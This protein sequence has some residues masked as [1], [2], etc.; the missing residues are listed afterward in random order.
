MNRLS[1]CKNMN[2]IRK[3][4][5]IDI[6]DSDKIE[7]LFYERESIKGILSFM[8]I[9]NIEVTNEIKEEYAKK[10]ARA[11]LEFEYELAKCV[12]KYLGGN[13][14]KRFNYG[15]DFDKKVLVWNEREPK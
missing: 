1:S 10:Y 4:M 15:V 12:D 9:N 7:G 13:V 11:F 8:K 14:P 6:A 3:E 5:K 2:T